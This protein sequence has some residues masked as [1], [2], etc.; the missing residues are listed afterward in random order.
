[1]TIDSR[2]CPRIEDPCLR[3][4]VFARGQKQAFCSICQKHVH[5]LAALTP[6][7]QSTVLSQS[8]ELCVRYRRLLPIAVVLL[9]ST[10][11]AGEGNSQAPPLDANEAELVELVVGAISVDAALE[12][13]FIES[14][15]DESFD[16]NSA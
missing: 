10:V 1:M 11:S 9:A 15:I 6:R 16:G 8:G 12:P 5:N 14:E 2:S 3:P 4:P 13:V 7:E